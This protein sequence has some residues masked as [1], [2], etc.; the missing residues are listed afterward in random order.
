MPSIAPGP[1][2]PWQPGPASALRE[3]TVSAERQAKNSYSTADFGKHQLPAWLCPKRFTCLTTLT[4]FPTLV[5]ESVQPHGTR[6]PTAA[7]HVPTPF[8]RSHSHSLAPAALPMWHA[9]SW[10]PCAF[11]PS[12]RKTWEPPPP[13]ISPL[14]RWISKLG[15]RV[16]SL[17]RTLKPH[18]LAPGD[19][20]HQHRA[21]WEPRI[22]ISASSPRQF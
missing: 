2:F 3:L 5:S 15:R 1:G 11:R 10:P 20:R 8:P 14:A 18:T 21:E 6:P 9:F 12:P 7:T 13:A 22:G 19:A 17:G 4:L 16:E